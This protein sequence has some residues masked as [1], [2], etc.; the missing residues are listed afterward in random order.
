ME[1]W[2]V[3]VVNMH[4]TDLSKWC[5]WL[6]ECI[7]NTDGSRTESYLA[8]LRGKL[9]FAEQE[10][11]GRGFTYGKGRTGWMSVHLSPSEDD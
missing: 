7:E 5:G 6:R 1:N 4:H 11:M 10:L 2:Q 9:E 3:K 8:E